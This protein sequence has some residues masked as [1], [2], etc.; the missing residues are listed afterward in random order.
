VSPALNLPVLNRQKPA[1]A[2]LHDVASLNFF[3]TRTFATPFEVALSAVSQRDFYFDLCVCAFAERDAP[4]L[5]VVNRERK[6][7][8]AG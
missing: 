6:K 7:S 8:V 5:N 3:R 1:F 2:S 4:T